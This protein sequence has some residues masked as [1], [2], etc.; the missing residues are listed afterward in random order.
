[1]ALA[2]IQHVLFDNYPATAG[3]LQGMALAVRNVGGKATVYPANR[4]ATLTDVFLGIA[5][6]DS[7]NSGNT[8]AIV[9]P[10]NPGNYSHVTTNAGDDPYDFSGPDFVARPA[11]RLGDYLNETIANVT[12]WTDVDSSGNA[13]PKRGMTVYMVGGRF[14]TDQYVDTMTTSAAGVDAGA[15][16]SWAPDDILTF[17]VTDATYSNAGLFIE[18][19]NTG[20]GTTVARVLD[21]DEAGDLLDIRIV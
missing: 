5:G 10:V 12:N 13:T 4:V 8:Q 11:R 21:A 2:V 3:I 17:G 20:H 6:D 19:A 15:A 18:L 7:T 1:M 9:D 14:R 16:P